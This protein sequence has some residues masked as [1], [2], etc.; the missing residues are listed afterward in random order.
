M[1]L[2]VT[3]SRKVKVV[4]LGLLIDPTAVEVAIS[5]VRFAS[6]LSRVARY[7]SALVQR[8]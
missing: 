2:S 7:A 5:G 3:A 4:A 8:T 6:S 1:M